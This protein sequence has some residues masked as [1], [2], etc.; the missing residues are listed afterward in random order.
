MCEL[1]IYKR[2]EFVNQIFAIQPETINKY[3]RL[4]HISAGYDTLQRHREC[5]LSGESIRTFI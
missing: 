5:R 2:I 1:R 4:Y 3:H